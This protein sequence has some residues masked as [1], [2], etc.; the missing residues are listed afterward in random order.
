MKTS[1]MVVKESN[2]I[3]HSEEIKKRTVIAIQI[4]RETKG[5]DD[6]ECRARRRTTVGW[7]PSRTTTQPCAHQRAELVFLFVWI[8]IVA[9]RFF[10]FFLFSFLVYSYCTKFSFSPITAH[11]TQPR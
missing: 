8:A 2:S 9:L 10:F 4:I 11:H 7:R 3:I 6:G 1:K 5:G